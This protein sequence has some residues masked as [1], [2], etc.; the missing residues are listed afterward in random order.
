MFS[1]V[2]IHW[3]RADFNWTFA[4]QNG[5]RAY[6]S[7]EI[8]SRCTFGETNFLLISFFEFN[9]RPIP[10]L[11]PFSCSLGSICIIEF[12]FWTILTTSKNRPLL[13][14][15]RN[16]KGRADGSRWNYRPVIR[17]VT[18]GWVPTAMVSRKRSN[19]NICK[20]GS[21]LLEKWYENQHYTMYYLSKSHSSS[22]E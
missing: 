7:R 8:L 1:G 22:F 17:H 4:P 6:I 2:E 19:C 12:H 14:W 10:I 20:I 9:W 3:K 13:L 18:L 15:G 21:Y 5:L 11:M 16:F